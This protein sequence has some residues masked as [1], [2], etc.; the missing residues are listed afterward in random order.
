LVFGIANKNSIAWGI[1]QVLHEH[2]AELGFSY[3]FPILEKRVRPLAEQ[4]GVEFVEECNIEDDADI[5]V[6]FQ[7]AAEH[8]GYRI[9]IKLPISWCY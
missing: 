4:L 2:G 7:K 3:G 5:A 8:F 6:T 1:S 9:F